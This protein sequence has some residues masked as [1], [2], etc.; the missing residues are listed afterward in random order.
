MTAFVTIM[1][2]AGEY[3]NVLTRGPWARAL[4]WA[5]LMVFAV[6]LVAVPIAWRLIYVPP[7]RKVGLG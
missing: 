6:A 1:M 5:G 4:T 3:L 2:V 7:C